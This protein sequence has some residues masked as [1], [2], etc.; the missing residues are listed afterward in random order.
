M[1]DL[2]RTLFPQLVITSEEITYDSE[3]HRKGD[4]SRYG[5][6][7]YVN[8]YKGGLTLDGEFNLE[9]LRALVEWMES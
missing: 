4:I 1:T 5:R 6:G 7:Q 3:P 8:G 9:E 2:V